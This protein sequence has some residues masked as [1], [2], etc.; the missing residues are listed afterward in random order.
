MVV[1]KLLQNKKKKIQWSRFYDFNEVYEYY[2][3]FDY[4]DKKRKRSL[5]TINGITGHPHTDGGFRL[6]S[7]VNSGF[8]NIKLKNQN[9][10]KLCPLNRGD[11]GLYFLRIIIKN[12]QWDYIGKSREQKL[13]IMDRLKDH[14]N[15]IAGTSYAIN[16][17][18]TDNFS[19][20]RNMFLND[21]LIKTD[22]KVF[23]E[24]YVKLSFLKTF[25][26]EEK[27]PS[28]SELENFHSEIEK[29]VLANYEGLKKHIPCLNDKEEFYGLNNFK[30]LVID[31]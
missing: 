3:V 19:K 22:E 10:K 11:L 15:K 4:S 14:F 31:G 16:K 1:D 12:K 5:K 30:Y 7:D 24:K 28:K 13:G 17:E 2:G 9:N 29:I 23:F 18:D 20:L 25:S 27:K 26:K 21:L 8:A 6:I